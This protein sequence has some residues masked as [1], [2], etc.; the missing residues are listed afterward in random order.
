MFVNIRLC[1][2]LC[3]LSVCCYP[4]P[5]HL[6]WKFLG[7]VGLPGPLPSKSTLQL[8]TSE[9]VADS[10]V[11]SCISYPLGYSRCICLLLGFQLSAGDALPHP[12]AAP[13]HS[14]VHTVLG[15]GSHH[16][17]LLRDHTL[18]SPRPEEEKPGWH[19]ATFSA[20]FQWSQEV[21]NFP[22]QRGR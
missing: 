21:E 9:V 11:I 14:A 19:G 22:D 7:R 2:L 1:I 16:R 13:I 4:F 10:G 12:H 15:R 5:S 6:Y 3:Y 8:W 18:A 17:S 20:G